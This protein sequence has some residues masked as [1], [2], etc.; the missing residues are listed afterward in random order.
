MKESGKD[1]Q[2]FK[3]SDYMVSA[4][5]TK[6]HMCMYVCYTHSVS[7]YWHRCVYIGIST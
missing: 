7:M 2:I 4:V 6:M 5:Q 1:Q 3:S